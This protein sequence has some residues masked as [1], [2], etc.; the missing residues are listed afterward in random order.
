MFWNTLVKQHFVWAELC[1]NC[2]K[3]EPTAGSKSSGGTAA[4]VSGSGQSAHQKPHPGSSLGLCAECMT[5]SNNFGSGTLAH[6]FIC[7]TANIGH[8]FHIWS[9]SWG[10]SSKDQRHKWSARSWTCQQ[11]AAGSERRMQVMISIQGE[12]KI[13][14]F[15][16]S[17]FHK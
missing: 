11:E 15:S 3:Q 13:G 6:G 8:S 2:R 5:P 17:R 9:T 7:I 1:E 4:S 16:S 14:D 12:L 10:D